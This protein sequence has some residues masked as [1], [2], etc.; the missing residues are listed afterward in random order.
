[1]QILRTSVASKMQCTD[2]LI[3]HRE[4]ATGEPGPPR[5]L[6][7]YY[8]SCEK[9][10]KISKNSHSELRK[11]K[12]MQMLRLHVE[13]KM[14]YTDAYIKHM[15]ANPLLV[16]KCNLSLMQV[17]LF[18]VILICYFC[19]LITK[20]KGR[21]KLVSLDTNSRVSRLSNLIKREN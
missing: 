18:I 21:L 11:L 15:P 16:L 17:N 3:K 9:R 5:F 12:R 14:Q 2:A 10:P 7:K 13:H 1:M 8:W 20:I 4:L 6:K 19:L